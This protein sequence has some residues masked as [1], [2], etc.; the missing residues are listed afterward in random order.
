MQYFATPSSRSIRDAMT[1]GELGMMST[2]AQPN[3]I[4][5]GWYWAADNGCFGKG[6]PGD[7]E[8]LRWLAERQPLA[9]MCQFATAPDVVG[10][11]KATLKRSAPFM[12][13]IRALGFP[14]ALVGQD[15]LERLP[16]PWD[17]FSV[18]FIGGSTEWKLSPQAAGLA[19][20]AKARGK[21]VHMGRVNS[22][23]RL[24]YAEAIGCDSADGTFL[25]FGPD[26]NLPQLLGWL[27]ELG[28]QSALEAA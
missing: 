5:P 14:V 2:P 22:R 8:Y 23:K 3:R 7:V 27:G 20:E 18:F 13:V 6:Y 26:V 28:S 1:R 10:D 25:A 24:R 15:G 19:A 21:W 9:G 4:E 11:A 16:V 12:P 17:A